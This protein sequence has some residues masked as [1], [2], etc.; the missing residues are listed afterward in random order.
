MLL[1][2]YFELNL[3]YCY[4]SLCLCVCIYRVGRKDLNSVERVPLIS[5][6]SE[7]GSDAISTQKRWLLDCLCILN[8]VIQSLSRCQKQTVCA[9]V[10]YLVS[11]S[12][13]VGEHPKSLL[14]QQVYVKP[15]Y[16]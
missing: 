1:K 3:G 2:L 10:S 12:A 16:L 7:S 11:L 6:G 15:T 4:I 8:S 14:R 9:R 13:L 5:V